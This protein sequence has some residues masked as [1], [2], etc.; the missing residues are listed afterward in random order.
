MGFLDSLIVSAFG[1]CIVFSA[2]ILI[3]LCIKVL[4]MILAA[5]E[6]S[7]KPQA[8]EETQAVVQQAEKPVLNKD[9]VGFGE[10]K[11]IN[12]D[13]KTAAMIMAIVSDE[14]KIPLD[15]LQFKTIKLI[16]N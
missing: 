4:T 12:V 1:L 16:E 7:E 6:K 3:S 15:E 9:A 2:L 14:S 5:T 10:L 13:E 8:K 11:L